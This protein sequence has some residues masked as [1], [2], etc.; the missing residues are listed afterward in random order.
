MSARGHRVCE[1]RDRG[2]SV[3]CAHIIL[4]CPVRWPMSTEHPSACSAAKAADVWRPTVLCSAETMRRRH[5]TE[6]AGHKGSFMSLFVEKPAVLYAHASHVE[7]LGCSMLAGV[8]RTESLSARYPSTQN[9][10]S[11]QN[12]HILDANP[13][14]CWSWEG[15]GRGTKTLG[16]QTIAK[17]QEQSAARDRTRDDWPHRSRLILGTGSS[18]K[19]SWR[20]MGRK[21]VTRGI[22]RQQT[23]D[24]C[25][26]VEY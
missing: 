20:R 24:E 7:M 25:K 22:Q 16:Q 9:A 3:G 11:H 15:C 10:F 17:Y 13:A 14:S 21:R 1:N 18:S 8:R 26:C 4:G 5:W 6:P 12:Q 2:G 19:T 23:S